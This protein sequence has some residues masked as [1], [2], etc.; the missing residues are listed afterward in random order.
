MPALRARLDRP[1]GL[2]R[3]ARLH[4]RAWLFLLAR[5]EHDRRRLLTWVGR[6]GLLARRP[7]IGRVGRPLLLR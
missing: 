4:L 2:R 7:L 5:V 3:R 1:A 6:P